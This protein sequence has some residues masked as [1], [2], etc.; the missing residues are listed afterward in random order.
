MPASRKGVDS[1]RKVW[2]ISEDGNQIQNI[3]YKKNLFLIKEKTEK[4][5]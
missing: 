5:L 4:N 1:N 3:L 2:G